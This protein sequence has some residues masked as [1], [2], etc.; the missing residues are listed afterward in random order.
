MAGHRGLA[1]VRLMCIEGRLGGPS[2]G[3]VALSRSSYHVLMA[4]TNLNFETPGTGLGEAASWTRVES[5]TQERR[6][7]FGTGMLE[8]DDETFESEWSSNEDALFAFDDPNTQLEVAIFDVS[9]GLTSGAENFENGWD[10]NQSYFFTLSDNSVAAVFDGES[11]EDF[12]DQ[13]DSNESYSFTLG[14]VSA[15]A[16][17]TG[18]PEAFEDFEEQWDSNQSYLYAMGSTSAAT[19]SDDGTPNTSENFEYNYTEQLIGVTPGTD[20]INLVSHGF[21]APNE[22]YFRVVGPGRLAGGLSSGVPFYVNSATSSTFKVAATMSGPDVDI[23]DNGAGNSYVSRTPT[24]FW[25]TR[26]DAPLGI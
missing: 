2:C 18:S 14:A 19:F 22:L 8:L 24:R 5:I 13:W 1:A 4:L 15:A 6:A 7:V 12:E 23:T 21:S 26:V 11:R 17:D 9:L 3:L 10:G 25:I 16:F 20:N